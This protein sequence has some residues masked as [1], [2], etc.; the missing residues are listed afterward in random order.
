[1]VLST[2]QGVGTVK[3]NQHFV[4]KQNTVTSTALQAVSNDSRRLCSIQ[5]PVA[6]LYPPVHASIQKRFRAAMSFFG[7]RTGSHCVNQMVNNHYLRLSIAL[8]RCLLR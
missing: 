5:Q 2:R 4:E 1:M 3:G 6:S 8:L 7:Y